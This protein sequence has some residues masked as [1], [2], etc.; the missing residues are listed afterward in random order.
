MTKL[1]FRNPDSVDGAKDSIIR[2]VAS[3]VIIPGDTHKDL[4]VHPNM[5]TIPGDPIKIELELRSTD[6]NGRDKHTV[7]HYFRT[8][9]DFRHLYPIDNPTATDWGLIS[10]TP[11]DFDLPPDGSVK[12]PGGGEQGSGR[13]K[14]PV[15]L[16]W[17]WGRS[18]TFLDASTI[19]YPFHT[20]VRDYRVLYTVVAR[21]QGDR[22]VPLYIS[23]ALVNETG[24][25]LVEPH[26]VQYE[27]RLF[28]TM[29]AEDGFG[30]VS[31][32]EDN[33]RSWRKQQAWRWDDGEK[34]PMNT[35]MTKLLSHSD[36]MVL[37]YTR[38][39]E[40]NQNVMRNRAPLYVAD[41]DPTTLMLRRSTE[42]AIVPNRGMPL[43][44]FWVQSVDQ[45]KSCVCTAE[46]PRDGRATNGDVWIAMIYWKRPNEQMSTD[47]HQRT[48]WRESS[49]KPEAGDGK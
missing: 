36:G 4:W 40:D 22:W 23:N 35:T 9:D 15:E 31:V 14:V 39:H 20:R 10:M 28:T 24:R 17:H 26:I 11:S 6:R 18:A 33:G 21:Q 29:R 30:Y 34:I 8:D 47:G 41:V 42:R 38:K 3:A 45:T 37:V 25:G 2:T 19:V 27:R 48:V 13:E 1:S 32:S 7:C 46:W 43:G 49:N 12:W 5:A 44:N 16:E